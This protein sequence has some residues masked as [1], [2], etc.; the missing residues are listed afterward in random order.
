MDIRK[1]ITG[2]TLS[3][4]LGSGVAVAADFDKG[5]NAYDS[6]DYKT[7]LA[8]WTPL[9]EQGGSDAQY[10]LGVMYD[11]GDGVPEN[12]KTAV[13]WYTLAAKQGHARAQTNLGLCTIMAANEVTGVEMLLQNY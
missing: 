2:L 7:A 6:G 1:I 13:K 9:A 5:I 11:F 10:N 4:L 3:L 12:D 8:E